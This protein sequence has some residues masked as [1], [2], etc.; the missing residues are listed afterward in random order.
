MNKSTHFSGQPTFCQLINL[1][2]K[3]I[4]SKAVLELSSDRYYK[5][6]NTFHHLVTMLFA[7]YGN[8]TSLREIVTGMAAMEG[9]LVS[10]GIR[11]LPTRSTF[12]DANAKRSCEVF[13]SIYLSLRD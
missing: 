12:A 5:K 3:E 4:I 10:S 11:H 9:R 8:C 2:P 6:F 1:I 7:C 13:E